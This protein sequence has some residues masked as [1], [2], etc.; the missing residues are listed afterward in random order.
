MNIKLWKKDLLLG[1]SAVVLAVTLVCPW[2]GAANA[3]KAATPPVA[4]GAGAVTR[5]AIIDW[6]YKA[7]DGRLYR[8][9]YNYTEQCWIGEWELCP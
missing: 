2:A 5:S 1:I 6:R 8:R 7:V 3:Y 4:I 9:Q